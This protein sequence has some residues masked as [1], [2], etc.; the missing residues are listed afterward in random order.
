MTRSLATAR[1]EFR[2]NE[3]GRTPFDRCF[4]RLRAAQ[5]LVASKF[6]RLEEVLHAQLTFPGCRSCRPAAARSDP[7]LPNQD[8]P[9]VGLLQKRVGDVSRTTTSVACLTRSFKLP[10]LHVE[11]ADDI[12]S[13]SKSREH[14]DNVS[15]P[16]AGNVCAPAIDHRNAD[17]ASHGVEIHL[18]H[19]HTPIVHSSRGITSSPSTRASVSARVSLDECQDHVH[20]PLL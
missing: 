8:L 13:C 3:L 4:R 17:D 16:T 1:C 6:F 7:P 2:P 14:L 20:T 5:S 9:F 15:I 11:C 12:Y 10:M 19:R 18:L